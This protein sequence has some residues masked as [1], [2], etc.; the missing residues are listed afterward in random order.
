[1]AGPVA[2][3][4]APQALLAPAD[5]VRGFLKSNNVATDGSAKDAKAAM[6]RVICV[7]K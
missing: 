4:A 1:L 7:R 2:G 5:L 3:T 6:V